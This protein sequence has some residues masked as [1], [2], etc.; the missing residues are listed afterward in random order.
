MPVEVCVKYGRFG[1]KNSVN[2]NNIYRILFAK[3]YRLKHFEKKQLNKLFAG[4]L[5]VS[6]LAVFVFSSLFIAAEAD[7]DC[8]G[9]GCHIC[10]AIQQCESILRAFASISLSSVFELVLSSVLIIS[11]VPAVL[12]IVRNTPVL[13]KVRL[14]N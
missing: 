8:C 6:M 5:I 4:I 11:M 2:F 3:G 10:Y 14:N 9:E 12:S 13:S 7:H 1:L